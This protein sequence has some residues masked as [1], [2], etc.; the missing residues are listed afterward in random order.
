MSASRIGIAAASEVGETDAERPGRLEELY[1][2]HAPDA[3]RL[4]YLLTG[5]RPLAEDLV[6][7]A[8]INV[9]GRLR[10]LRKPDA[11]H[12]YLR[13][14]VLNLSRMHFRRRQVERAYLDREVPVAHVGDLTLELD[15]RDDLW[16]QLQR[17][18]YRQRAAIVLRYCEGLS[19]R[20][21]AD[22]LRCRPGTVRSL[23]SRGLSDLRTRIR[24]E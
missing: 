9:A 3:Y 13:R 12:A 5:D 10:H 6:Q 17:L 23:L 18:P 21:S 16:R 22:V 15:A 8:F 19:D 11:F 24:M 4:A 7:E 14:T 2:R 1:T 20:E